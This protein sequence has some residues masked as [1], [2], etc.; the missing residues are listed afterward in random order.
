M[1]QIWTQPR[2]LIASVGPRCLRKV[3]LSRF[4]LVMV[5]ICRIFFSQKW[6]KH[7]YQ[8][9]VKTPFKKQ[10]II[11]LNTYI[12]L[13]NPI[14]RNLNEQLHSKYSSKVDYWSSVTPILPPRPIEMCVQGLLRVQ[15]SCNINN[16]LSFVNGK[17]SFLPRSFA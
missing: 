2:L 17:L 3:H 4:P 11:W 16:I 9:T 1:K 10:L 15:T 7:Q 6:K 8:I 5:W 13:W 12:V 14:N